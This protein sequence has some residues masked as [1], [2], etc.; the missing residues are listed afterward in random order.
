VEI[1]KKKGNGDLE[2]IDES[3]FAKPLGLWRRRAPWRMA[4]AFAFVCLGYATLTPGADASTFTWSGKAPASS[5]GWSF[6]ANWA[7]DVSPAPSSAV[8]L[9]FPLLGSACSASSP[10]EACYVSEDDLPGLAA[11][12][13][14]VSDGGEYEIGGEDPLTL[15]AGGLS[16]EPEGTQVGYAGLFLPI[17]LSSAQTWHIA[18]SSRES[19][20]NHLF[21]LGGELKGTGSAL[22]VDAEKSVELAVG[23]PVNAGPISIV[24]AEA[25][26][27]HNKNAVIRLGG[28]GSINAADGEPVNLANVY[29]FGS[30]DVGALNV[31]SA[32]LTVGSGQRSPGVLEA[33]S[34]TLD[35]AAGVVFE[36]HGGG[37]T[38][39]LDY[40]QL[41]VH[42]NVDLGSAALVLIVPKPAKEACQQ[43]TAGE[44]YTLVSTTGELT[45]SFAT[46]A[47]KGYIP[48]GYSEACGTM[49]I[50]SL[51]VSYQRSGAVKTVTGTVSEGNP[52]AA[53]GIQEPWSSAGLK[54][55][56][57][58][59][60]IEMAHKQ[61]EERLAKEKA[62]REQMLP[63]PSELVH[64]EGNLVDRPGEASLIGTRLSVKRGVVQTRIRCV[65]AS[66]CVGVLRLSVKLKPHGRRAP[67]RTLTRIGTAGFLIK[68]NAIA[69]I[70]IKLSSRGRALLAAHKR[71]DAT[72]EID[73]TG[74]RSEWVHRGSVRLV[75]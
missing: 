42:G 10:A 67:R 34:A 9:S 47:E 18:G 75:G 35:P 49:P 70:G 21:Y 58:A 31:Q 14:Q 52:P 1:G 68:P 17:T 43:L 16:S 32:T 37:G 74:Q 59:K 61:E 4:I 28:S 56:E 62:Q 71:L 22:A 25:S 48:I 44:T 64:G 57:Q 2:M 30:G 36:A 54:A 41:D 53:S 13:M 65:G 23:A 11:E 60:A 6:A 26:G 29:F 3:E 8:S 39:G 5:I 73:E 38:A 46:N 69:T 12:S 24:G 33:A 55:A 20:E 51:Q 66:A 40:S 7:G 15:G 50:Q 27:F 63:I 19:F 72:L 45:G